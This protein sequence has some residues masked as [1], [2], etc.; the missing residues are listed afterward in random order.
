[1][2]KVPPEICTKIYS[3]ACV[4]SGYT[5]RSLSLVSK[6]V[7]ETSQPVKLQSIYLRG[8]DQTKAFASLLER[9]PPHLRFVRYLLISRRSA[10]PF[11][12]PTGDLQFVQLPADD[13]G[14]DF[15]NHTGTPVGP[16]MGQDTRRAAAER[17][18][19]LAATAAAD[20]N[21]RAKQM[22]SAVL[23]ILTNVAE[24]LEI[25]E[26]AL[27][28]RIV[29]NINTT[30][31]ISFP[32]LKEL[33]T[34]DGFPL[35]WKKHST[36]FAPCHRLR[37][38]HIAQ[39]HTNDLFGGIGR[40]APFL[41]HLRFSGLQQES[42]FGAD[43]E[44]ALGIH[45]ETPGHS[46]RKPVPKLPSTVETVFVKPAEPPPRGGWCGTP[47]VSY[48]TLLR[49]LRSLNEKDDRF[50]L[51]RAPEEWMPSQ[52]IDE[53]ADWLD[54]IAGG[55]GCWTMKNMIPRTKVAPKGMSME[56]FI[57]ENGL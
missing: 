12:N 33:T 56:A 1:M 32:R 52:N 55:E 50:V 14:T 5:G 2:D 37:R 31:P 23:D 10:G 16:E 15:M 7:N 35:G 28:G 48:G 22:G 27:S 36:I 54:R 38:L 21:D 53:G 9:T 3:H 29:S 25:L 19:I 42:W 17:L 26:V 43:L 49:H 6:F 13:S 18:R 39:C 30:H 11:D 51:L 45:E 57:V 41:T 24:S 4:D 40:L 20:A 8:Y 47:A 34:H 44:V 46:W